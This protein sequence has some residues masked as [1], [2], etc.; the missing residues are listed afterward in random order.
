MEIKNLFKDYENIP[1]NS[2]VIFL[3]ENGHGV[4]EFQ[5]IKNQI[6]QDLY[7]NYSFKNLVFESG[8]AENTFT[9][10]RKHN[11]TTKDLLY[12]SL[13]EIWHTEELQKLFEFI[14]K[15]KIN[16]HGIDLQYQ[17]DY[18]KNEINTLL[19]EYNIDFA[20]EFYEAEEFIDN[21]TLNF[22]SKSKIKK[23]KKELDLLYNRVINFINEKQDVLSSTFPKMT[24]DLI[25]H[26]LKNRLRL[27][28]IQLMNF[29]NY[30]YYRDKYMYENLM[31]L[32]NNSPKDE[33]FIVYAHN[34]HIRKNNSI[35]KG[36]LNEKTLGEFYS[37]ENQDSYHI[38][39]YMYNGYINENSRKQKKVKKH[40]VKS[41]EQT[42][43]G[44][45]KPMVFRNLLLSSNSVFE[46]ELI[47]RESGVDKRRLIPIQQYDG[48]I[49]V[50][51]VNPS[52]Y[53]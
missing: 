11:F 24:L 3:G 23:N 25:I 47:E 32:I 36:W 37:E 42:L 34:Y 16:I 10:F 8:L 35:T 51:T 48:L 14:K 5:Y 13:Y 22:K 1:L 40:S 45:D 12:T 17:N 39:F 21:I 26:S 44:E 27:I 49:G 43:L 46:T 7:E 18:F 38:G 41:L 2:K 52:K 4:N 28:E 9:N 53:I 31:F 30:S 29:R 15:T 6:I 20:K 19:K 33:K 50:K